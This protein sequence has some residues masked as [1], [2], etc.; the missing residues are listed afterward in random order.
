MRVLLTNIGRLFTATDAGVLSDAALMVAGGRIT[1]IGPVGGRSPAEPDEVVDLEG[2]LVTPGLIDAH[3]HPV[4]AGGRLEEIARRSRGATYQE[5]AADGG[6][7]AATVAATRAT[8]LP[9]LAHSLHDRL[10]AWLAAGTTTI[11]AKSGYHLEREGELGVIALLAGLSGSDPSTRTPRIE[12]TFLGAHDLPPERRERP[13]SFGVFAAEVAAW[14]AAA[15]AAGARF[16]DVFCDVGYFSVGEAR[17]VLVAGRRAGLRPRVHADELERTGASLLAAE[18]G[19]ASADHLLCATADDAAALAASGV[20][21]TLCPLTALALGR[22]PPARLLADAGVT[23]ALGTDHNPGQ[24]GVTSMSLVVGLAVQLLGL[25]VDEALVAATAGGARAVATKERGTLKPG[26]VADL[27]QWEADHEGAFVW[28]PGLVP[29]R[30][31][32]SGQTVVGS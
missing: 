20:V 31:W 15:R 13:G 7:I 26:Q 9:E 28:E 30:V 23:V 17:Q 3:T 4:H 18:L 22:L 12:V 6:G 32:K 10:R 11:E 29:R 21:A 24:S 1:W 2:A 14:S 16:V 19:A 25:S 5:I 8:P 27:V